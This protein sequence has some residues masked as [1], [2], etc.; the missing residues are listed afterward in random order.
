MFEIKT[1]TLNEVMQII[2]PD[3]SIDLVKWND[4]KITL[5]RSNDGK[6]CALTRVSLGQHRRLREFYYDSYFTGKLQEINPPEII[7][8][9]LNENINKTTPIFS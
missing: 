1:N 6:K 7:N 2:K 8:V 4:D 5:H 9:R 3:E